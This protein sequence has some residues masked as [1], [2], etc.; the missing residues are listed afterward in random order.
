MGG[1]ERERVSESQLSLSLD[2]ELGRQAR[3]ANQT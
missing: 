2:L 3:L 1:A